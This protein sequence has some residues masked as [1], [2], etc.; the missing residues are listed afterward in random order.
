MEHNLKIIDLPILTTD[1]L[2]SG[3]RGSIAHGM[4]IPNTDP[5]SI[6]DIDIMTVAMGGEEHYFGLKEWGS[7]G[8]KEYKHEKWDI[9]SF[10]LRKAFSLWL[11]GNPNVISLLWIEPKHW[12]KI[13][14]LGQEIINN[15][16]MFVGKHV[17]NAFAGYASAQ[18][19]KMESRDPADLRN[20]MAIDNEMKRRGIHPNLKGERVGIPFDNSGEERNARAHSNEALRQHWHSY[21]KK[22]DNTGYLGDKRKKLVLEHGYDSKNAAH[23]IRLLRM[24]KEFL[25]TGE[26]QV[27]RADGGELLDIKRGKWKLEDIKKHAEELFQDIKTARDNSSLPDKPDYE[28]AEKLLISIARRWFSVDA[29]RG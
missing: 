25:M 8:T 22:G 18:L 4:Y 19:A 16:S 20:Y 5:N 6:D 14:P 7:R 24:C 28:G 11:Q 27:F 26:M 29:P 10:E 1:I 12:I 23:C 17:Y 21:Q 2:L 3:Y 15:R 9:V 13:H